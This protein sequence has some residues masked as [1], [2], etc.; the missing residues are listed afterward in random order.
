MKCVIN[1]NPVFRTMHSIQSK[2]KN[3][4]LFCIIY[5][6]FSVCGW[7]F[8]VE[9]VGWGFSDAP[10]YILIFQAIQCLEREG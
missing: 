4:E 9:R 2:P 6:F 7:N 10:V 1:N 5:R 8:V 3:V